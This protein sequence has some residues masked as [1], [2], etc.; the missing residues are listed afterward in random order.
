MS[1]NRLIQCIGLLS[2]FG[3]VDI[4]VR[5]EPIILM[6]FRS[7]GGALPNVVGQPVRVAFNARSDDGPVAQIGGLYTTSDVGSTFSAEPATVELFETHF[8]APSGRFAFD[9][10]P[11]TPTNLL[12]DQLWSV[13]TSIAAS[14]IHVPRLG[15]GL[16]GYNLTSI[17]QTLDALTYRMSGTDI[18][19]E[20]T[21]TIRLY[22]QA[23]PEPATIAFSVVH[24][25][26]TLC[27][28]RGSRSVAL[29]R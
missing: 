20:S 7:D 11:T 24:I 22:G 1:V 19:S 4:E 14:T 6:E 17:T 2:F 9:D 16:T 23:V 18:I 10:G 8:Q 28:A 12:V 13:P 21:Q 15:H 27:W 25:L 26:S 29:H 5:A 3:V